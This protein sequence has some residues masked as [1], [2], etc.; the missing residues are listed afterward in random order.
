MARPQL[1][2]GYIDASDA[3]LAGMVTRGNHAAFEVVMRRYNRTL[4]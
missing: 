2:S 1:Q 4:C 3:A